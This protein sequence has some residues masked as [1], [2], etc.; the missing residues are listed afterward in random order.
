MYAL[1][2][3]DR[4]WC[5]AQN[6]RVLNCR[7]TTTTLLANVTASARNPSS[8]FLSGSAVCFCG[9]RCD[10]E[11]NVISSS[12]AGFL[13]GGVPLFCVF[14][15][16]LLAVR[17]RLRTVS[18]MR[19]FRD[20][21]WVAAAVA[22][23]LF[24]AACSGD[25]SDVGTG[26]P[27]VDTV[28]P[29]TVPPT[30]APTST[31]AGVPEPVVESVS[32][33]AYPIVQ[34]WVDS[35]WAAPASDPF[36]YDYSLWVDE[37][38]APSANADGLRAG[39]LTISLAEVAEQDLGDPFLEKMSADLR[40]ILWLEAALAGGDDWR[41][42]ETDPDFAILAVSESTA[43]AALATS[44]ETRHVM[45]DGL[46]DPVTI[47]NSDGNVA[48]VLWPVVVDVLIQ[49]TDVQTGLVHSS[50]RFGTT[51]LLVPDPAVDGGFLIES[52]A[53]PGGFMQPSFVVVPA[54]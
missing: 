24:A 46:H 27:V 12:G 19:S 7:T 37:L 11:L 49:R 47:R 25:D 4:R 26:D 39:P 45:F 38:A 52:T 41:V 22:V 8:V 14:G 51:L 18:C 48:Q 1:S 28:A 43:E 9:D 33:S 40:S 10:E 54:P 53:V 42:F 23:V 17:C 36:G 5:D 30:T 3:T 21:C 6:T 50:V 2:I 32:F 29:S 35:A 34:A 16:E 13:V 15:A 31:T 20:L 44:E